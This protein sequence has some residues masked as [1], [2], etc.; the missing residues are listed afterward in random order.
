[1][2]G[3][4]SDVDTSAYQPPQ[5]TNA[6]APSQIVTASQ[7]TP[8]QQQQAFTL[9][10]DDDGEEPFTAAHLAV[11]SAGQVPAVPAAVPGLAFTG[12]CWV[13]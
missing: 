7:Q 1:M 13:P 5:V 3:N 12:G 10:D 2:F 8:Q 6:W 11:P 4:A 9:D